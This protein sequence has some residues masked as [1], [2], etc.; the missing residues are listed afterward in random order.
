MDTKKISVFFSVCIAF[1]ITLISTSCNQ[2]LREGDLIITLT[3]ADKGPMNFS[4]GEGWRYIPGSQIAVIN[5]ENP[6]SII[7]LTKEFFSAC[8][9]DLL[10]EGNYMLFTGQKKEH[11]P[12]QIWEMDL[13]MKTFRK[14]G[15]SIDNCTD[16]VYLP[17]G[18]LVFSRKLSGDS[19]GTRH[20]L[21]TA[22]I[23]GTDI[24]QIT[25]APQTNFATIIL[26]DGR[27]LTIAR[28]LLPEQQD[29]LYVVMRHDGTK[30]DPF[31]NTKAGTVLLNRCREA[32]NGRIYFVEMDTLS[33]KGNIASISYNRPLTSKEYH[34]Y[35]TTGSFKA[36]YPR[37][38]DHFWVSY[39]DD[40]KSNTYA[41]YDFNTAQQK[42]GRF[43]YG[44][45][46]MDVADVI[47][48]KHYERPRKLPSEVDMGVKTGLLICLDINY[49]EQQV[50][51]PS[52]NFRKADKIEVLG[53]D[54]SYGVVQAENDG[55]VY[56][57]VLADMPFRIQTLNS[58]GK[59]VLEPGT[60]MWLRPNE[61]RGFVSFYNNPELAPENI[62][63]LAIKKSPVIIP[64]MITEV[65]EKEV[66]LE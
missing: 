9:P 53:V 28:Q 35:K 55:S 31:C 23:N 44:N 50:L 30:A 16:P 38:D 60:W 41:L 20:E 12:W 3:P 54:T 4:T 11:D 17:L 59:V 26:K 56:L 1:S 10:W 66:E 33:K 8:S 40:S 51:H 47:E 25:F 57:K 37:S 14:V 19:L 49:S 15:D 45:E 24:R 48:I 39:K 29:P 64:I 18:K 13:K 2:S 46:K 27:L 58:E 62:V 42:T 22:N 52:A 21:F 34:T 65:Q 6:S 7:I 61:R 36:I 32:G 5:P 43:I 63:P